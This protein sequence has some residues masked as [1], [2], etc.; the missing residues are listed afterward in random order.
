MVLV[1]Q[2]LHE[3]LSGLMQGQCGVVVGTPHRSSAHPE[4]ILVLIPLSLL[5]HTG[6]VHTLSAHVYE[7]T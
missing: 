5:S 3:L 1:L 6:T 4:V 7:L 2:L